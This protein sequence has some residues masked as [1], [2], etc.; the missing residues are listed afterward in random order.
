MANI[1]T[2]IA[3]VWAAS[4]PLLIVGPLLV[5][6]KKGCTAEINVI[7]YAFSL[8]LLAWWSLNFAMA[9]GFVELP[10]VD[11][12]TDRA[13]AAPSLAPWTG[14][15]FYEQAHEYLTN[16]WAELGL[17]TA[18]IIV[19]VVPQ[20]FNYVLS[21][22]TGC[23]ATPRMVWQFEK[24]AIWS[25]IKF[26]AAFG[27]VFVA[28]GLGAYLILMKAGSNHVLM[29]YIEYL[30]KGLT[31]VGL[32][33]ALTVLQVLILEG[34]HALSESWQKK[35]RSLGYRLH[36]FFTRNLPRED[37]APADLQEGGTPRWIWE[38]LSLAQQQEIV[39]FV[40][41][42]IMDGRLNEILRS[43]RDWA[44]PSKPAPPGSPRSLWDKLTPAQKQ[45]IIAFVVR[46]AMDGRLTDIL[47]S[48]G[49]WAFPSNVA[50]P[51]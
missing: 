6:R 10:W 45:E 37:E 7:W 18:V 34:A 43:T 14:R 3:L 42:S 9:L 27:G 8:V 39:T 35:P 40:V 4:L 13:A 23:A 12:N 29:D 17:V 47:R 38:R 31:A 46:S 28:E 33:F 22:L 30:L 48:T 16:T 49:D 44:F 2:C 50:A 19:A 36:R 5:L 21:G 11:A 1:S 15:W 24:I 32:A 20:L 51:E 25:L 41:G 26:L